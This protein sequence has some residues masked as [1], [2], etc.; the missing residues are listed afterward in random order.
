MKFRIQ[1]IKNARTIIIICHAASQ[2][3]A[4]IKAYEA[5]IAPTQITPIS[6]NA[7]SGFLLFPALLSLRA[8]LLP[9]HQKEL[10]NSFKQIA[11]MLEASLP[12]DEILNYCIA[13]QKHPKIQAMY[14]DIL[15][16]LHSGI[17]LSQAFKKHANFIGE[18]HA[19]IIEVGQNTGNL[20]ETFRALAHELEQDQ[21]DIAGFKKKMF[22][23]FIV[24]LS[25]FVAFGILNALIIPEFIALFEEFNLELPFSTQALIFTGDLLQKWG[26]V[27]LVIA[28]LGAVV[29]KKSITKSPPLKE[30]LHRHILDIP[31]IGKIL[32]YRDLTRC[33]FSFYLCVKTGM[34]F[35]ASLKNAHASINNL[36]LKSSFSQIITNI[37]KG[38]NLSYALGEVTLFDPM[39]NGLILAGEKSG[40]LDTTLQMCS[41]YYQTLYS[42]ALNRFS[43][44]V[45]P[46]LTL[47]VGSLVLWFSLGIMMPMW[48]LNNIE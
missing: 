23:P 13:G 17:S 8:F 37:Q 14:Q 32:R 25:V 43:Q 34:D 35:G 11:L 16:S 40:N 28:G 48:D 38:Q 9:S 22:Y 10:I 1:G 18:M 41:Q 30:W 2:E 45:E 7:L 42:E 21:Q 4:K 15:Q 47:L 31:F 12:I 29:A 24:I 3:E 44:W 36:H 5:G 39:T 26:L 33:L 6:Q 46:I 20:P 19:N 27:I